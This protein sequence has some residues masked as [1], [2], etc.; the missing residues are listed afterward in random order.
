[1]NPSRAAA[2]D[3]INRCWSTQVIHAAVSLKVP[4]W[5]SQG[6]TSS[7][8]LARELATDPRAT[9][10]LLRAMATLGLCTHSGEDRFEL[11]QTGHYLRADVPESLVTLAL[12]WGTRTWPA[13]AHLEQ[14]VQS[15]KPWSL[16][17]REGFFSMAQR[18]KDAQVLNRSMAAL[19]LLVAQA[20]VDAY[21]FSRFRTVIDLGGG[22]GALLSALLKKYPHLRGG[23]A[24]L[25]YME[26]DATAF[27][28]REGVAG[29]ARFIP[30]DFF[31]SVEA[32]ADC[33][34]LKYIVHDWDDAD[35]I[36]ILRNTRAAAGER[37]TVLIIEQLVPERAQSNTQ[38][39]DVVRADIQMMV[40]TGGMERTATEYRE[41]L[42][43][44]GLTLV[45][46]VPSTSQ[47]SL[48]EAR[49]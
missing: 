18:P 45:R 15:G 46:I 16:G 30:T 4:D 33:Y 32:G 25:P 39:V 44:A 19:T 11:T 26:S 49:A 6:V 35:S 22:Y 12:H 1:M 7:A 36:A 20:I 8:A 28:Q 14:S 43:Q 17:G 29:R 10:R 5:L 24:D 48:I 9:F 41:L 38:H 42:A 37:G 3:L 21:D 31:K 23:S 13:L 34:L 40:S 27:L 47:F 2:A